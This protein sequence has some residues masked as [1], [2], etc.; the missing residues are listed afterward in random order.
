MYLLLLVIRVVF[1]GEVENAFALFVFPVIEVFVIIR[2]D[3]FRYFSVDKTNR[4]KHCS[5]SRNHLRLIIKVR[6]PS[7]KAVSVGN[8]L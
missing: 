1:I 2:V 6:R 4:R 8:G 7:D 3:V 5:L